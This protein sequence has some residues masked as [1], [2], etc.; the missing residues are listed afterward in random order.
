MLSEI[1]SLG[2]LF[3]AAIVTYSSCR[4]A[5]NTANPIVG[6]PEFRL[7]QDC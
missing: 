2:I 1:V 4:L 5:L 7:S 3:G 6:G